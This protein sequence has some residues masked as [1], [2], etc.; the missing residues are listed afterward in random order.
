MYMNKL[1]KNIF[2]NLPFKE[3]VIYIS[4]LF[5]IFRKCLWM[6]KNKTLVKRK[7]KRSQYLCCNI[8]P[9]ISI[10]TKTL[11]VSWWSRYVVIF[12]VHVF[13]IQAVTEKR[14][15]KKNKQKWKRFHSKTPKYLKNCHF[16][17][18]CTKPSCLP[19]SCCTKCLNKYF[20]VNSG[21][22][23]IKTDLRLKSKLFM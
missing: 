6:S 15:E 7:K 8:L 12:H 20:L 2:I 21:T 3:F 5:Y 19:I 23:Y 22:V 16:S 13:N 9:N 18:S 11:P 17:K 10:L 4:I 1:L 14:Y